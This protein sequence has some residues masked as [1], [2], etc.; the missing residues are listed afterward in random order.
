M[1]DALIVCTSERTADLYQVAI[2]HDTELQ[3]IRWHF[4]VEY[5][6]PA[7]PSGRYPLT[8]PNLEDCAAQQHT[9]ATLRHNRIRPIAIIH[10]DEYAVLAAARLRA[11]LRCPGPREPQV[12][13]FRDKRLMFRRLRN[14]TIPRP[15]RYTPSMLAHATYPLIVK[16]PDAAAAKGVRILAKPMPLPCSSRDTTP[17]LFEEF[18]D[19]P[20][21]H[22]DGLVAHGQILFLA[23]SRYHGTCHGLALGRPLGSVRIT[24]PQECRAWRN[25]VARVVQAMA[26]PDGAIHLEAIQRTNG[27]RVFLEMAIRPGGFPIVPTLHHA[28][29]IDLAR[30]HVRL[31]LNLPAPRPTRRAMGSGFLIVPR[32]P[33]TAAPVAHVRHLPPL[34]SIP[35][36]YSVCEMPSLG[37]SVIAAADGPDYLATVAFRTADSDAAAVALRRLQAHLHLDC[38][39]GA[40]APSAGTAATTSATSRRPV[41]AT[42]LPRGRGSA[43]GHDTCPGAARPDSAVESSWLSETANAVHPGPSL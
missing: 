27:E 22:C 9:I 33:A 19:G 5:F 14:T 11:A 12:R 31:G 16:P 39:L 42:R 21:F 20:V 6:G 30:G 36:H 32:L 28:C 23:V 38:F 43:C 29:G 8:T 3:Q 24:H 1:P 26:P 13:R 37:D 17:P 41:C 18:I 25:F 15:R 2:R 7:A 4:L 35:G 34:P 10:G 40:R